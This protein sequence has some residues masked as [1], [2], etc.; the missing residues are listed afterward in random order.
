METVL[1]QNSFFDERP[2][3]FPNPAVPDSDEKKAEKRGQI[4]ALQPARRWLIVELSQHQN[5]L[6]P[7]VRK[8]ILAFP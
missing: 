6:R 2:V 5:A 8:T 7:K 1:I 3:A 4:C